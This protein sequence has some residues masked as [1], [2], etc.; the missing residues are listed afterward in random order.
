MCAIRTELKFKFTR[1]MSRISAAAQIECLHFIAFTGKLNAQCAKIM[2][3]SEIHL[4]D[5]FQE[6]QA[7]RSR[8]LLP[9]LS[10]AHKNKE[11]H[12]N[13]RRKKSAPGR[14]CFQPRNILKSYCYFFVNFKL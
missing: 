12:V 7:R 3:R 4:P 2:D 5:F 8:I 6:S 1:E 10:T 9:F 13:K 14:L 11:I